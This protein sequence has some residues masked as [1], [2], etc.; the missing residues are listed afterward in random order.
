[1]NLR[2]F[3]LPVLFALTSLQFQ[4]ASRADDRQKLLEWQ[5]QQQQL[6]K[7][8]KLQEIQKQQQLLQQHQATQKHRAAAAA[9]AAGRPWGVNQSG[10]GAMTFTGSAPDRLNFAV[11]TLSNFYNAA[12]KVNNGGAATVTVYGTYSYP[13]RGMW[14]L[15]GNFT[16]GLTL[17]PAANAVRG[18]RAV[19]NLTMAP[20]NGATLSRI[21]L[22]GVMGGN[23]FTANFATH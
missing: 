16:V 14:T 2:S 22:T 3:I 7:Q 10:R 15:Q 12:G 21:T 4:A 1:M 19:G 17:T 23:P 13:L 11:V 6:I 9:A 5:L 20:P 18:D 8:W